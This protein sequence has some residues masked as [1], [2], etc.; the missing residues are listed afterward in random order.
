MVKDHKEDIREF[1]NEAQNGRDA[2][3][4]AFAAKTLPTLKLHLSRIESIASND[5]VKTAE[6]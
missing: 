4:K 3:A 5:G 6:Q 2:D 1:E